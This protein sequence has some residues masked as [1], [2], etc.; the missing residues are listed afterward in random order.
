MKKAPVVIKGNKSG[1]RLVLD[2]D[3]PFDELQK[4]IADKFE[5]SAEF[6]GNAQ[7]AISFQGPE[8]SEDEENVILH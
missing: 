1:I 3:I 5:S 8:L 4:E 6:L 7:V 2:K